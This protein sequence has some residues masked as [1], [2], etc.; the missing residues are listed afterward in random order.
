MSL[1]IDRTLETEAQSQTEEELIQRIHE[2]KLPEPGPQYR[3]LAAKCRA[4]TLTPDEHKT[5][6]GLS[7]ERET[8][9]ARRVGYLVELAQRRHTSLEEVMQALGIPL[10]TYE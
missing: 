3:A 7:D 9:N 4:G 2:A 5:L 10:G 6:I 8:A 1:T